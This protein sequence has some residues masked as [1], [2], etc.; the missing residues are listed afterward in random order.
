[1]VMLLHPGWGCQGARVPHSLGTRKLKAWRAVNPGTG[2]IPLVHSIPAVDGNGHGFLPFGPN[3]VSQQGKRGD[4]PNR[5]ADEEYRRRKKDELARK[6][7]LLPPAG[8]RLLGPGVERRRAIGVKSDGAS[9]A[10]PLGRSPRDI[11]RLSDK[12][13]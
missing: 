4:K 3:L 7:R 13:G 2:L 10:I 8:S 1:M 11:R 5:E 9:S 12:R 6:R